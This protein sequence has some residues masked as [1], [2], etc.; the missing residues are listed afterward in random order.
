M[1]CLFPN[2][3]HLR[4]WILCAELVPYAW[5]TISGSIFAF[6]G[7][8]WDAPGPPSPSGRDPSFRTLRSASI[9]CLAPGL[10]AGY[11]A[12]AADLGVAVPCRGARA[13]G[14]GERFFLN[15]WGGEVG[16]EAVLPFFLL[17]VGHEQESHVGWKQAPSRNLLSGMWNSKLRCRLLGY[18]RPR[19]LFCLTC[20]DPW[21]TSI[22]LGISSSGEP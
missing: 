8:D 6:A 12:A 15:G 16:G 3:V 10:V 2:Q 19:V 21:I 22:S 17:S 5:N 20:L 1:P 9:G 14:T 18:V 13:P 11:R 4:S 7:K